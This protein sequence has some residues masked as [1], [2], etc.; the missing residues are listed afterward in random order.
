MELKR[1]IIIVI[2]LFLILFTISFIILKKPKTIEITEE[3][4]KQDLQNYGNIT[5]K[6]SIELCDDLTNPTFQSSCKNDILTNNAILSNDISKCNG[7]I[8]CINRYYTLLA[9]KNKDASYCNK[10]NEIAKNIC[11]QQ[12]YPDQKN[13]VDLLVENAISSNDIAVC[14]EDISCINRY[15]TLLAIK[16]KDASY[17]NKLNEIA[18]NICLQQVQ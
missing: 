17:C 2:I 14:K 3:T 10:L 5:L 16:N 13:S 6:G 12:I 4:N 7:D 11:L 1:I 15:Y 18:K 8:S 9:I